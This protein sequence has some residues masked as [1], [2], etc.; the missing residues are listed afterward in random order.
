MAPG[1]LSALLQDLARVADQAPQP[2]LPLPGAVIG[3]FEILREIG[4]G[5]FG[6]V[7][8]AR[9]QKLHRSV[10]FKLVRPGRFEAGEDLLAREAEVVA[11]LS[12]PNLVTLFD[13]GRCDQGPYLVLEL[14]RGETLHERR[15][16]G[17]IPAA[18][19]VH[20]AAEVARGLA[21]AHGQGVVHR[22]LKPSNV[23]L[24]ED[25]RVKVLD[26]GMARAFGRRR[27][28]GG[29]PAYM[30]PEQWR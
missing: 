24:C 11:Q 12:H 27:V 13:V 3:R 25:G 8:E 21:H 16:S 7:Y 5:G 1:A 4:G 28:S 18:E 6:V 30:A 20:V 15:R 19:A 29:T 23:F 26:F 9:D 10:A 17:P 2:A 22:D 14:L